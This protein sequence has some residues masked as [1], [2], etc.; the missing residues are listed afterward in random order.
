M[1]AIY[2]RDAVVG[3]SAHALVGALQREEGAQLTVA[4]QERERPL[5]VGRAEVARLQLCVHIENEAAGY[6]E[7]ED[8]RLLA[9][10]RE[11]ES[12]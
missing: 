6:H 3:G 12:E 7:R 8:L 1:L 9:V 2:E 10:V 5:L 11:Q 4:L